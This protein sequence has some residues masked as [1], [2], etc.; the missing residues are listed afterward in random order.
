MIEIPKANQIIKPQPGFQTK[1]LSS[2]A[3]ILIGG[4]SAGGGKTYAE[5]LEGVR[6]T[7]NSKFSAMMF[8]RTIPQIKNPG[9]LW[10]TAKGIYPLLGAKGN[11]NEHT[12]H[13]PS[14]AKVKFSHLQHE[15]NIYDH[16][17]A[18]YPLIIYDEL[19]HFSWKM[20]T[21]MLSRNRSACGVRPYIRATCNPDPDSWVADFIEWWIDQ[22]S[23]FPIAE[24]SGILRYMTSVG[25][26][27]VWGDSKQEVIEKVPADYW[28]RFPSDVKR[29]DLIK[30][31]TFIP[32]SVYENKELLKNDPGYLGNLMALPADEQAKLLDGNWKIRTDGKA[33]FNYDAIK[34]LFSNFVT[35]TKFRCITCDAARF[36]RD[37][38]V[39]FVWEGWKVVRII[40]MMS[41]DEQDIVN[42]IE[43]QRK[44]FGI[45]KHKVLIDQD[46]VGGGAVGVGGYKGFQGGTP[47]VIDPETGIKEFY[48][49]LKTQCYYRS[50][51]LVNVGLVQVVATNETVIIV[52]RSGREH[53]SMKFKHKGKEVTIV[54]YIE[55]DLRAIKKKDKD[56][57]GKKRIN[58]KIEQKAILFGRSP[59]FGDNFCMRAWF[60]LNSISDDYG[61]TRR[62]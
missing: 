10:D 15:H 56:S 8:R 54:M 16:Q 49:N 42:A 44:Q 21:Y 60:E 38:T 18:Q 13:F 4:G 48:A 45:P 30:S 36:G 59:D 17:G 33:L 6:H 1:F 12:W 28:D 25:D 43:S 61:V 22:E 51:E 53:R 26:V 52:D 35:D 23:G 31:V 39:I 37:F 3:D 20:F 55:Q 57:E 27:L 5:L 24:R 34:S 62:N 2:P 46:G 32:G 11:S 47:A 9:G 41:T 7:S 58:D 50:A 19:T 40:V 14:G 29:T